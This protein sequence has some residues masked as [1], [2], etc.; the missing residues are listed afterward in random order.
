MHIPRKFVLLTRFFHNSDSN[1]SLAPASPAPLHLIRNVETR[2]IAAVHL[3]QALHESAEFEPVACFE[4]ARPEFELFPA[5]IP[6]RVAERKGGDIAGLFGRA[7]ER[8]R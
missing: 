7:A 1:K 3:A 8:A 5:R 6:R 2:I 4:V